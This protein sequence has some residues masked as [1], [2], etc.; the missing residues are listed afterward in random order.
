MLKKL[1]SLLFG[2]AIVAPAYSLNQIIIKF[3]PTEEQ[4]A[5][6]S[7]NQI[8]QVELNAQLMQPL[9]N[10]K[11]QLILLPNYKIYQMLNMLKLVNFILKI[12]IFQSMVLFNGI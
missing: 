7:S 1:M 8:S 2:I 5:Q 4:K 12:V 11:I 10:E 3:K 6:L 9:T